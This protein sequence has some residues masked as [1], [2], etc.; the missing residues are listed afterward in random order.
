LEFCTSLPTYLLLIHKHTKIIMMKKITLPTSLNFRKLLLFSFFTVSFL[1]S[2]TLFAQNSAF[3]DFL[4]NHPYNNRPVLPKADLI[5]IPVYER[6]D[7]HAEFDYLR[8]VDPALLRVP[9]E[10]LNSAYSAVTKSILDQRAGIKLGGIP[11]IDNVN[12]IERGPN[13]IGGRTRAVIF[14][15]KDTTSNIPSERYR[16][17]WAGSAG[18]GLWYNNDI[19]DASGSW[20][21]VNDFWDNLAIQTLAY[22]PSNKNIMYAGTGEFTINADAISGGGIWRTIDGGVTWARLA[23]TIPFGGV[24]AA[25]EFNWVSKIV[26]NAK[27]SVFAGTNNGVYKSIDKGLTW[28]KILAPRNNIGGVNLSAITVFPN[29]VSDIEIG[30][31]NLLY[32]SMGYYSL[33]LSVTSVVEQGRVFKSSDTTGTVYSEITPPFATYA[34]RIELALAPST[35]GASQVVYAVGANGTAGGVKYFKKSIDAGTTWTDVTVPL[36]ANGTVFTSAQSWYDLIL[37]VKPNDPNT[38][39]AGGT[40][41]FRTTNG[42]TSWTPLSEYQ[43]YIHPDMHVIEFRP[44]FPNQ[45][46]WANDGGV[47]YS[48]DIT[49]A[50][51]NTFFKMR[52]NNYN[53]TQ[54]YGVSMKNLA[55]RTYLLCGAQDNGTMNMKSNSDGPA[56]YTAG[57]DG[58]IGAI[59]QDDANIQI[60]SYFSGNFY[61]VDR[62]GNQGADLPLSQAGGL[63]VDPLAYDSKLNTLF[64]CANRSGVSPN[65]TY[66]SL[67]RVL[68]VGITNTGSTLAVG[69]D[70][71]EYVSALKVGYGANTLF[72]A[73]RAGRIYKLTNTN[74]ATATPVRIDKRDVVPTIGQPNANVTCIELGAND[75]EI[76][77]TYSNFGVKSIF[78]TAD[79]GTTWTSKDDATHGLPDMPIRW[80]LMNPSDRKQVLIATEIGVWSTADITAANPQWTVTNNG[81][82][83]VRSDMIT[84]READGMIAV[85]T[86][87]RG[88]F[89]SDIFKAAN[90]IVVNNPIGQIIMKNNGNPINIPLPFVPKGTFNG[91]NTFTAQLSDINGQFN[92]PTNLGVITPSANTVSLPGS[93][94][95]GTYQLRVVSSSP[96]VYGYTDFTVRKPGLGY[97]TDLVSNCTEEDFISNVTLKDGGT[98]LI[99]STSVC[100]GT[101]YSDYT[102]T[103]STANIV[104]GNTYGLSFLA[105]V[106]A[107]QLDAITVWIDFNRDSTFSSTERVFMDPSAYVDGGAARTGTFVVPTNTE[108]GDTRMRV[109]L[110]YGAVTT[111]SCGGLG[112]G[113]TEDYK[114]T[115]S[116][117]IVNPGIKSVASGDWDNVKTWDCSCVPTSTDDVTVR[118]GHTVFVN[119]IYGQI[120]KLL[121]AGGDVFFVNNGFLQY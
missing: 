33:A 13:N 60:G 14:D 11:G 3:E 69:A 79:G 38:V 47:Y 87:G 121:F 30:A 113:E 23:S 2:N 40:S 108:N 91:G 54:F 116:G 84:Y 120:K 68:N 53:V 39:F 65:F 5:K 103:V 102:S 76:L 110:N 37:Q 61:L 31:D 16:K 73:T 49:A 105:S 12:W 24:G 72:I 88:V 56:F 114:I 20:Q 29:T 48:P 57:G 75:N 25:R 66:P 80:A 89:I 28:T 51:S 118:A 44:N 36:Y 9:N 92:A 10:R 62:Y 4:N 52:N 112:Y 50:P 70:V 115:I 7:Y 111:N 109:R 106:A 46:V 74:L 21:K 32:V 8:T 82:A 41:Y 94:P 107:P 1:F 59:D 117:G 67:N 35:S 6:P 45:I 96:V 17:V 64:S 58:M 104:A 55:D 93:L 26:V 77:V 22:D 101:G 18:G 27:G 81:L 43:Q 78:Y 71:R 34:G 90:Q 42:G 99:N 98:D 100:V 95:A 119:G 63:F 85:A 86:H 19:T 97:C 15:P 83:N